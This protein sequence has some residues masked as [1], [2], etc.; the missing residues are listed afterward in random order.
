M[1]CP[2]CGFENEEKVFNK[3]QG[4]FHFEKFLKKRKINDVSELCMK[5]LLVNGLR[6]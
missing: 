2:A 6:K 1:K 5:K 4:N 3:I